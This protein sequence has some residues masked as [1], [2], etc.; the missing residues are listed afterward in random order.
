VTG[1]NAVE[2]IRLPERTALDIAIDR[3]WHDIE[4]AVTPEQRQS[5]GR[6]FSA[7][8]NQRNAERTEAQIKEIERSKGLRA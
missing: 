6:V 1:V 2:K 5:R 3:A 8:V 7:L 4:A